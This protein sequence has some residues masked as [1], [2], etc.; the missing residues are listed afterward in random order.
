[1]FVAD[2]NLL[3]QLVKKS[4]TGILVTG[5]D[6]TLQVVNPAAEDMITLIGEPIGRY[7]SEA[8]PIPAIT[9]LFSPEVPAP[10]EREI[11]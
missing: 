4:P 8:I 5:A 11:Q 7:P 9:E 3:E 6:G 1:M 10:L 2:T